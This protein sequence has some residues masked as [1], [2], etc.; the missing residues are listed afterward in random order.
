MNF[1]PQCGALLQLV[2]KTPPSLRCPKC[3]YQMP[4]K[5]EATKQKIS[6]QNGKVVEIAIVDKRAAALRSLATI[7]VVCLKCGNTVSEVW[8]VEAGNETTHS[9]V[10]FFRCTK[11]KTTTR[12]AG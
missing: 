6:T 3:K 10:T 5:Q 9:T 12:E 1:C 2:R 11:C 4:L 7:N 8:H